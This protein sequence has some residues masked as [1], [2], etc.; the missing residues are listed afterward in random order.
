MSIKD[1]TYPTT[2]W[3]GTTPNNPDRTIDAAPDANDWNQMISELIAVQTFALTISGPQSGLAADGSVDSTGKQ[4]FTSIFQDWND[5]SDGATVTFDLDLS[6]KH[7]VTIADN[8]TLALS[9]PDGAQVFTLRIQQDATGSRTVTW[10][11]TIKWA[12]GSEPTLTTTANKADTF[13]F[14]RTGT[15]TYDGFIVGQDI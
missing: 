8:R 3:G 13:V 10:F 6:N 15:D 14:I 7:R 12:G 4:K 5:A 2:V 11:A 9:N 1:T